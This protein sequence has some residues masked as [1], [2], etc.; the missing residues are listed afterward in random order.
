M[1]KNAEIYYRRSDWNAPINLRLGLV[2]SKTDILKL[3]RPPSCVL[4]PLDCS[5]SNDNPQNKFQ[6][7]KQNK[8]INF[9]QTPVTDG[10]TCV[11]ARN[12]FETT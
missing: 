9:H 2:F 6:F 12:H 11:S 3:L 10:V 1:G 7:Y 8:L 4:I 5:R